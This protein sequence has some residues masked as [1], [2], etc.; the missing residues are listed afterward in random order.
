MILTSLRSEPPFPIASPGFF[1]SIIT[2]LLCGSKM[3][4]SI[5]ASFG[6]IFFIISLVSSC[7]KRIDLLALSSSRFFIVLTISLIWASPFLKNALSVVYATIFAPSNIV[8]VM[9]PLGREPCIVFRM[10]AICDYNY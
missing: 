4:F 1:V 3:I 8:E 2:M 9:V 5:S 7:G 10:S 6:I